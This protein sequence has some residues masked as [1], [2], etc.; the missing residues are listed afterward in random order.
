MEEGTAQL[1]YESFVYLIRTSGAESTYVRTVRCVCVCACVCV[2]V[3]VRVCLVV[4]TW[5]ASMT[6]WEVNRP[7]VFMR[8]GGKGHIA[9]SQ[10]RMKYCEL[11]LCVL[12]PGVPGVPGSR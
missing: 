3:C 9:H 2:C 5:W 4:L 10:I 6:W 12:L 7:Q 8:D 1:V 11:T